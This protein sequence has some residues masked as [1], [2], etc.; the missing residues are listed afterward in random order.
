VTFTIETGAS[1]TGANAYGTAAEATAYL[2]AFETA[3]YEAVWPAVQ[4]E[5]DVRRARR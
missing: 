1:V 3:G 5:Q 2:A 4:A